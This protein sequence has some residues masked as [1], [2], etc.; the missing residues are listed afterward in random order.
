MLDDKLCLLAVKHPSTIA[1]LLSMTVK[2]FDAV[3]RELQCESHTIGMMTIKLLIKENK[4][5]YG[6]GGMGN[7]QRNTKTATVAK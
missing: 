7:A 2:Q 6:L 1:T 5:C 3:E 4:E